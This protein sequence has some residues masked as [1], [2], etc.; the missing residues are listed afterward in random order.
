MTIAVRGP[1]ESF[2]EMA[3]VAAARRAATVV[4]LEQAETRAVHKDDFEQLRGGYRSVDE[5]CLRS[6]SARCGC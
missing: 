6:W 5:R 3:L 1:G 2:G 4:A